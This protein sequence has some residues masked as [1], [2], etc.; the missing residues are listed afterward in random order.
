[1]T[2][3]SLMNELISASCKLATSAPP[4]VSASSTSP[5]AAVA[6]ALLAFPPPFVRRSDLTPSLSLLL[7]ETKC[8]TLITAGEEDIEDA[9]PLTSAGEGGGP[10]RIS[11]AISH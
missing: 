1:M 6:A 9:L 10:L 4:L 2:H 5:A 3:L 11:C 8:L 7:E